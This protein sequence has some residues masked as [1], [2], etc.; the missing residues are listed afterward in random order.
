MYA[1]LAR[2]ALFLVANVSFI[3]CNFLDNATIYCSASMATPYINGNSIEDDYKYNLGLRKIALFP[4]Q[5]RDVFYDGEEEELSDNALFGAVEGLEYL[6]SLSS[7]R[8]QGNE[9]TDQNYW[10]K[11]SNKNLAA[12]ISYV[13]KESRDLQFTSLDVRYRLKAGRFNLT[14]GGAIKAHPI[15]GHPA[16]LDYEGMWWELAYEYGFVDYM[17]PL[18]DLN[19]NGIIDD[20]YVWIETDPETEEG[21]WIY[22]YEE[23][24]YYWENPDG[25]Y[26][27]GSDEEFFEYHY[28]HVVHMYNKDN[29]TKDWQSELSVLVGLDFYMG[30]DGYYS[31][32]W[33]NVFPAS[34]GLTDKAFEGE[35]MQYDVG[36]LLGTNLSERIGVFIEGKQQ[37]Y[38]GKEEYNISTGLNWRF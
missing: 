30:G 13:D 14:L 35:D 21:Y 22:Y 16:I 33:V 19:E 3:F 20:Y 36:I 1:R 17:V 27:A 25:Q 26:I 2:I 24:N 23:I 29:K 37:S 4:Y 38:Y 5:K 6:F 10:L 12:K 32:I 11:W 31:H 7:I 8:H 9:F 28:P 15:Y 34:V 18:H